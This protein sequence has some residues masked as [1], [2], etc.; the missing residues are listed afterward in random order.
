MSDHVLTALNALQNSH[1]QRGQV[2]ASQQPI[3]GPGQPGQLNY[4]PARTSH[5]EFPSVCRRPYVSL[6]LGDLNVPIFS[7]WNVL[8]ALEPG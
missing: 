3:Q 4:L 5:A 8:P 1:C 7:S 2:L 6:G